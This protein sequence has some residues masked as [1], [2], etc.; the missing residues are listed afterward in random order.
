MND[1]LLKSF[2]ENASQHQP[3]KDIN[4][5]LEGE[6]TSMKV[7]ELE[8]ELDKYRS[9]VNASVDRRVR[10]I[11]QGY[12]ELEEQDREKSKSTISGDNNVSINYNLVAKNKQECPT[13]AYLKELLA[14][15][16][17]LLGEMGIEL[18]EQRADHSILASKLSK[19]EALVDTLKQENKLL[20]NE[21]GRR[22]YE[23]SEYRERKEAEYYPEN[24][25]YEERLSC[26]PS[27]LKEKQ[28]MIR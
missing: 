9:G 23:Q 4:L 14:D 21:V 16:E 10:E 28:H 24:T 12:N 22:Q 7:A 2:E 5:V 27:E 19:V 18:D 26:R 15:K 8:R 1:A 13:C 11:I 25:Y 3:L 20:E 17:R 6:F